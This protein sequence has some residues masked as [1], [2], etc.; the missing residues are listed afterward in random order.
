[1]QAGQT[2]IGQMLHHKKF[3][4]MSDTQ[5]LYVS[6]I[7]CF[8]LIICSFKFSK[9]FATVNLIMFCLYSVYLYYNLFYNSSDGAS[10]AWWF[11]AIF[12]TVLQ[13][14]IVGTYLGIKIFS[15][16]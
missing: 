16:T 11:Y 7:I 10:L 6:S 13:I 3:K 8:I 2:A 15:K 14:L 9:L 12:F 4:K 1:M 5:I